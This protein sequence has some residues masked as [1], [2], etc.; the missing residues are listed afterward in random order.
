[1]RYINNCGKRPQTVL[2]KTLAPRAYEKKF[3]P[4]NPVNVNNIRDKS[5]QKRPREADCCFPQTIR[6][7]I[8]LH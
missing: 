2:P 8:L 6:Q 4:T 5:M 1:M 3:Y 7:S